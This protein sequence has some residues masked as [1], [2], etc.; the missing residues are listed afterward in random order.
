MTIDEL[1]LLI[2]A[3]TTSL[4][5]E[6]QGVK[7]KLNDLSKHSKSFGNSLASNIFK[8]NLAVQA[9]MSAVS[10]VSKHIGAAVSRVD[11]LNNYEKVMSN[12][13]ISGEDAKDSIQR[14]SDKLVG[15]PTTLDD[16]VS[17][18][19]RFTSSNN[20]IK[21]ST[22]M[23]LALNNAIL[24]G[25]A[26]ADIQKSALEQLS[27]SY[28]KGKPDMMEWRTAMT[29][30]PAQLKQVAQAMGYV[31]ADTLGEALRSGQVSMNDFMKTIYS[32]NKTGINGFQS[33]EE[34]AKNSTGGISTSMISVKTALVRG[35]AEIMN[36][37]GQ[38]NIAG[39]FQGIARAINA[40]VPYIVG[41]VKACVTAVTYIT[42]LFGKRTTSSIANVNKSIATTNNSL[43]NFGGSAG[44]ASKGLDKATGSAK[45]LKKELNGLAAFDEMNVL[46]DNSSNDN[47]DTGGGSMS[48]DVGG[49]SIGDIGEWDLSGWNE[50]LDGVASKADEVAERIKAS[51]E[52]VGNVI[53][54][55]WNAEPVQAFVGAV[56]TQFT[57][58]KDL[59]TAVGGNIYENMTTTWSN[60]KGNVQ[61]SLNNMSLFFTMFF[62]DISG[63]I[64]KW[65][66]PIID[67][68]K[69]IFDSVWKTA[70]DP[71]LKLI[72]KIWDYTWKDA[73][74]IWN[75]YGKTLLDNIG[76]FINNVIGFFKQIWDG[77]IDPIITPFLKQLTWLWDEH[78]SKMI[79]NVKEFVVSLINNALE[80]YNKFIHPIISW[81]IDYLY[82]R[83]V[84]VWDMIMGILGTVIAT[85]SDIVI[86]WIQIFKGVIDFITGIFT[87]NWRKAWEGVKSIFKGIVDGLVGIIKYPINLIIDVINGFI[88]GLNKI[89]IPD[90]VPL[91][92]GKGINIP[93]I[94]KL[95]KG[96]IVDRPTIA[97]VG[98]AGKEAVIPLENNTGGLDKIATL[99]GE[100]IDTTKGQPINLV[101]KLGEDTIYDKFIDNLN[102]RNFTSNGEVFS[103]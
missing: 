27:Q 88:A 53:R 74:D 59:V 5:K 58:M 23:F 10:S 81:L 92:G 80:I 6:L 50:S 56:H 71:T 61:S 24:V 49:S 45:K 73:V 90:W 103:I 36:A 1:Q 79:K 41:F 57:F 96:G 31:S 16:A 19:Q 93:K 18:V 22:D 34:Q 17:S 30:M 13:G 14:L 63:T 37:I 29:A 62:N 26:S 40:V 69:G 60:I 91:V 21:A 28:S 98:E 51:F 83:W 65:G 25:G 102:E 67:G 12:L 94:P 54:S 33:F 84:A 95:A 9:L 97:M 76:A 86:M 52:Q 101:I 72:S 8:G 44:S 32:L 75:K 4:Q 48:A 35:L 82:P 46:N 47:Q 66:K 42:N 11:A 3:N 39:F 100:K 2:T 89:K 99:I 20:N 70:V 64:Q 78:I 15:L 77:I 55:I 7:G 43:S 68:V 85:M 87:G 38:S